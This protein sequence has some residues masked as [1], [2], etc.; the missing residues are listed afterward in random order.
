M[1]W[2]PNVSF[3]N[4]ITVVVSLAGA[5]GVALRVTG[6]FS[7]HKARFDEKMLN[8]EA[9]LTHFK[10]YI[11]DDLKEIKGDLKISISGASI[12]NSALA[13]Q[14]HRIKSLEER[15]KRKEHT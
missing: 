9:D 3:G 15:L 2:D 7:A 1:A 5:V 11:K 4:V 10:T 13:V 12:I 14:D 6:E 8:M